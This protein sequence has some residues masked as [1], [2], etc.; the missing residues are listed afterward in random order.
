MCHFTSQEDPLSKGKPP[1]CKLTAAH[2]LNLC[3]GGRFSP[4]C[5]DLS[6]KVYD[7]TFVYI[8]AT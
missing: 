8:S 4:K 5:E 6:V 7:L 3:L 2:G 1:Q